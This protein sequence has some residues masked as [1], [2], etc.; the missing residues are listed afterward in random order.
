LQDGVNVHNSDD[1]FELV[2]ETHKGQMWAGPPHTTHFSQHNDQLHCFGIL[3]PEYYR[4]LKEHARS[5][6]YISQLDQFLCMIEAS[7]KLAG[8]GKENIL[9]SIRDCGLFSYKRKVASG[10]RREFM[11]TYEHLDLIRQDIML[12]YG[13]EPVGKDTPTVV[14]QQLARSASAE[15]ADRA[16]EAIEH[17]VDAATDRDDQRKRRARL[18]EQREQERLALGGAFKFS[19]V[20][21][22]GRVW[23]E[24]KSRRA[25]VAKKLAEEKKKKEEEKNE[26]QKER[27]KKQEEIQRRKE[28]R[29]AQKE[30]KEKT[31][32]GDKD[33][34]DE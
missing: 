25:R 17:I 7:S 30:S 32:K 26:K 33:E 8:E 27:G 15:I 31:S 29:L 12:R 13:S 18:E 2:V 22:D 11:Y 21:M 6:G 28:E 24:E 16:I 23:T 4:L 20:K 10:G 5:Y 3:K 14:L 34:E 1:A 19:N 9:K